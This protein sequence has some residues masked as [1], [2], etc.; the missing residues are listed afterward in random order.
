MRRVLVAAMALLIVGV[1]GMLSSGGDQSARGAPPEDCTITVNSTGDGTTANADVTLREAISLATGVFP[2]DPMEAAQV[3]CGAGVPGPASADR[4]SFNLADPSTIA[5]GSA[6]PPL[7]TGDDVID[8]QSVVI[9]DGGGGGFDCLTV[10]SAGNEVYGLTVQNCQHGIFVGGIG[11]AFNNYVGYNTLIDNVT[12]LG[13]YGDNNY[14]LGNYIGID[15]DG[16]AAPN[17]VGIDMVGYGNGIG[18]AAAVPAGEPSAR[19]MPAGG[20]VIPG[21]VISGN[22]GNGILLQATLSSVIAGNLIGT[23]PAGTAAVPNGGHGIELL[24]SGGITIGTPENNGRNV[25][26]GNGGEGVKVHG[27]GIGSGF[28]VIQANYIG[29]NAAGT[30]AIPNSQSGVYILRATGNTIGGTAP[31]AGN[32]VSG[33][34]GF[35]GIAICGNPVFCGG[36]TGASGSGDASGT[37]ILGNYVGTN[38][39]GTASI[40]NTGGGIKVDGATGV[41]IGG[42]SAGAR[43]VVS[44]NGDEGIALFNG[45]TD[46]VVAG[47]YIGVDATGL[48]ALE[49]DV[50]VHIVEAEGNQIGQPGAGN[51]IS[52]NQGSGIQ[53]LDPLAMNNTIQGNL[54]GVGSDG[55]TPVANGFGGVYAVG[56]GPNVIGGNGDGEANLIA[57]N[58]MFGVGV[59]LVPPFSVSKR[60]SA[61]SIHSN[62]GLGIDLEIDGV[63]PNDILDGDGGGNARQNY[64]GLTDVSVGATTHLEGALNSAANTQFRIEFFANDECDPSGF[65]EGERY[66]GFTNTTTDGSGNAAFVA[67]LVASSAAAGD[68]ITATATDPNDNTSEFSPC[69]EAEQGAGTPA[70]TPTPTPPGATPTPTPQPSPSGGPVGILGDTDCDNDVD[71]VDGLHVLQDAAGFDPD[72]DCLAQGDVQCDGDRDAVDALGILTNVAALPPQPQEP[73]CP[74][75]GEPIT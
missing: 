17:G 64:P 53:L 24:D 32:V 58:D 5:L 29:T 48:N 60:V 20:G 59:Q 70:P 4:I 31:G 26:S 75:I 56:S 49:N 74:D 44:G 13:V 16:V 6:L 72:A 40:Q 27:D 39:N 28:N 38:A 47:N 43:N 22:T 11:F 62:D 36:Q 34:T 69:V 12:G 68:W 37:Q 25:I 52:G 73:G 2:V 41:V 15:R 35:A 61:N 46:S 51:V 63:T 21:N 23:N 10:S 67:D 19:A 9:L 18:N 54:I 65:G 7:S 33:N 8:A 71:A 1:L 14:V 45:T 55:Q 30:S 66:L 3:S 42:A 50:G 57:H